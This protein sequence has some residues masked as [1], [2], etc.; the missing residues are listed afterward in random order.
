[1]APAEA[2]R[3][4]AALLSDP[5]KH[6]RGVFA[7]DVFGREVSPDSARA[8]CW[9]A[10]G[11]VRHVATRADFQRAAQ[12]LQDA[13]WTHFDTTPD[14]VNDTL[15]HPAVLELIAHAVACAERAALHT[16]H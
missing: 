3:A 15:G 8:T 6:T 13:A 16:V 9:C 14:D 5:A 2:L 12:Y 10:Y 4:A 7:R 1:M 11:A